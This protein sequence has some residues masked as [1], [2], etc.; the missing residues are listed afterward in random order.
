VHS[1][2]SN[3]SSSDDTRVPV[4]ENET[5]T[6]I[7]LEREDDH[8]EADRT[9]L[10]RLHES[11]KAH[12]EGALHHINS[13]IE[14]RIR[15]G[16][17]LTKR[18]A[19][20]KHGEWGPWREANAPYD[21]KTVW[22]RMNLYRRHCEGKLGNVPNLTDSYLQIA[23]KEVGA[24]KP[25][26]KRSSEKLR[27]PDPEPNTSGIAEEVKTN[28]V[29]ALVETGTPKQK[30]KAWVG[31]DQGDS[32]EELVSDALGPHQTAR[33]IPDDAP[34]EQKKTVAGTVV[35]PELLEPE[36]TNERGDL[37]ERAELRAAIEEIK[38]ISSTL[39]DQLEPARQL[40]HALWFKRGKVTRP[41]KGAIER[42]SALTGLLW[43]R[44]NSCVEGIERMKVLVT[45]EPHK[46]EKSPD[47]L[48][49]D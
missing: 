38:G 11:D 18:R 9:E 43:E 34:T 2:D 24:K 26:A 1:Q 27:E 22:N 30:A 36:K 10:L 6:Q 32:I 46:P 40:V 19:K 7:D 41:T 8:S 44:V 35:E 25:R 42:L 5:A 28:A 37:P 29:A 39:A 13:S 23:G 21:Q 49:P 47:V 14:N 4:V 31:A 16:E 15:E 45:E 20:C 33:E 48:E 12:Q 17:I 3:E